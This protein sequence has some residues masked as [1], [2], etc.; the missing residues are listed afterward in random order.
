MALIELK[1]NLASDPDYN[2]QSLEESKRDNAKLN[3]RKFRPDEDQLIHRE[4]GDGYNSTKLDGGFVRGG[5]GLQAERTI[6]DTKRIGKFLFSPKGA[7]FT[8]KQSVLQNQNKQRNAN[9]YDPTSI[10]KNLP[11]IAHFQRH[12]NEDLFSEGLSLS[13]IAKGDKFGTKYEDVVDSVTYFQQKGKKKLQVEYGEFD[14]T[15]LPKD[16]IKF[17]IRDLVN[18][19]WIIF[20]A[21]LTS[22][23]V[24][25]SQASYEEINY[26]GR[27]DAVHIYK[28]TKRSF[29][30]GFKVVATNKDDIKLIWKKIDRLKGL[31]QPAFKP[32]LNSVNKI[33]EA[34][35]D[36]FTRPT[37][38]I[39]HFT[40]GDIFKNTVGY[41]ESVNITIPNSST[42]ELEDGL[43]FPHICDVSLNFTY[44]GN[45]TPTN[46]SP[47]YGSQ[48]PNDDLDIF[49][50][51]K[52]EATATSDEVE[53]T[54][55][56]KSKRDE[57]R[58]GRQKRRQDRRNRRAERRAARRA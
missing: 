51:P 44:I 23:I 31:T 30:I 48:N 57:R 50:P 26:V 17:R 35:T 55:P 25:N 43:Q 32:F 3:H 27:P 19:K 37:A 10:L 16:F 49:I 14:E 46:E 20:P 28:N 38:P 6:E 58:E 18:G 33:G 9:I 8:L 56:E 34:T 36:L 7:L 41:F 4:I 15:K 12:V 29:S 24:D 21:F 13:G 2:K 54:S 39:V 22:D 52:K 5:A 47:N 42:W 11:S 1:S 45:V 53:P 40:L